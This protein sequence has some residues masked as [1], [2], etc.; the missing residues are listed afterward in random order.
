[1]G[2]QV[3]AIF[4]GKSLTHGEKQGNLKFSRN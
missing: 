4:F 2:L 3:Q 1:M